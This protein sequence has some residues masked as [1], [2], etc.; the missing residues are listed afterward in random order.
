MWCKHPIS[1]EVLPDSFLICSC[2]VQHAWDNH[3]L[4]CTDFSYGHLNFGI[5]WLMISCKLSPVT[6]DNNEC[7]VVWWSYSVAD[8][9]NQSTGTGMDWKWCLIYLLDIRSNFNKNSTYFHETFFL[10]GHVWCEITRT[11]LQLTMIISACGMKNC[12]APVWEISNIFFSLISGNR[13]VSL[14]EVKL[15]GNS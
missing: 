2:G 8:S 12:Y 15:R 1:R 13:A 9:T 7:N 5:A 14:H 11:Q 10:K 3:S 6:V 4:L